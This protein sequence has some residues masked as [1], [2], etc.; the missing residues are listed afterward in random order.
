MHAQNNEE[1]EIISE[2]ELHEVIFLHDELRSLSYHKNGSFSMIEQ[3]MFDERFTFY[4]AMQEFGHEID[5]GDVIH[6]KFNGE[7]QF[8]ETYVDVKLPIFTME[9]TVEDV[10]DQLKLLNLIS[11]IKVVLAHANNNIFKI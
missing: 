3:A 4:I 8:E 2:T 1:N 7:I 10:V 9:Y 5:V 11:M 6:R